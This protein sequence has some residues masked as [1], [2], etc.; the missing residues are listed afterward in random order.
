L[1]I[2]RK[3]RILRIIKVYENR[4]TNFLECAKIQL[5]SKDL[6][7]WFSLI[8]GDYKAGKPFPGSF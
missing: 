2:V 3:L 8:E 1:D 7:N 4:F 6:T 5:K